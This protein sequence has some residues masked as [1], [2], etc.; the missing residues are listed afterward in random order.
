[1]GRIAHFDI[2]AFIILSILLFSMLFRRMN[3]GRINT[4]YIA[5]LISL[6]IATATDALSAAPLLSITN[7]DLRNRYRMGISTVYFVF[8]ILA[9][10]IYIIFI[11]HLSGTWHRLKKHKPFLISFTLPYLFCLGLLIYNVRAKSVFHYSTDGAYERGSLIVV[12]YIIGL[13]YM[14]LSVL[15][16]IKIRN[17]LDKEKLFTLSMIFPLTGA[18]MLFQYFQPD[19]L[20]EMFSYSIVAMLINAIILRPEHTIDPLTGANSYR[21]FT[22]DIQKYF[23]SDVP[24]DLIFVRIKN[25]TALLSILGNEGHQKMQREIAELLRHTDTKKDRN[26]YHNVYYLY[27][28]LYAV[29]IDGKKKDEFT[30]LEARRIYDIMKQPLHSSHLDLDMD[31]SV[32]TLNIPKDI[33]NWDDLVAF[34][35][36]FH[37]NVPDDQVVVLSEIA[38]EKQFRM[39]NNI[40]EI[41][42]NG[43]IN[44]SFV[45]YY[46]PIY[47]IKEKRFTSAEAL[48]RLFDENNGMVSPG[49]F[50]PYAEKS[51]S[52]H[53]IGEFVVQDVCRFIATNDMD[54]LGL[55]YV[56]INLSAVQ[57]MRNNIVTKV[58][59]LLTDYK[60]EPRYVNFEITETAS[61]F[62]HDTVKTNVLAMHSFGLEFALDD[63]GTGY[64]N[65]QRMMDFPFKLIKLDKSFVDEWEDPTMRLVIRDTIQMLKD[66]GKEIVVEG[67][68]TKEEAEWFIEQNCDYIQG[69]YYAKPMPEQ[70]FLNFMREQR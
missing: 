67:V 50:I 42:S 5:L 54:K 34:A 3:R 59:S 25:S 55:R 15:Y 14:I 70:E 69:F 2:A 60:I 38:P 33:T 49:I 24:A 1:M 37:Y 45:M 65:L 51:G 27:N 23:R 9:G 52:I 16:L 32:C 40:D 20:M 58:N 64:S 28:G 35:N 46:Q 13:Y 43:I 62:V 48:I 53:Q 10:P 36:S 57:C 12:F 47:S 30:R 7:L 56:E 29:L 21:S 66:I 11:G 18:A 17:T 6:L 68:E 39:K 31:A 22:T 26:L 63:Y 19:I 4:T 44:H 8:R 61:D 41:I